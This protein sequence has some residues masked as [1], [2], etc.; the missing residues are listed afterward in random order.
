MQNERRVLVSALLK[1]EKSGYSNLILDNVL[2]E[3]DLNDVARGFVTSAFYGVIER[4]ISIDHILNRYLKR[5][6]TKAPPFTAAVLRSGAYQII[7]MDKIP[8]SA[9][10]NESVKI[11]KKS[12]ES[13]NSGL[14]NAV[15]RKLCSDDV[16]AFIEHSNDPAIRF[17]VEKWI[18]D[19]ISKEHSAKKAE[20]FF[21]NALAAPP[22]FI[23]I[24]SLKDG[25]AELLG[26]ELKERGGTLLPTSCEDLFKVDG[27]KNI[28]S[29]ECYK[30]GLFF[31]QDL[32]SRLAANIVS[33]KAGDRILDCC[34]AP[35]GKSFSVAIE[36][37]DNC[38]LIS[39]DIHPHRVALIKNGAERLGLKSV[40]LTVMDA[41]V[42]DP[43]L[44]YFDKVL[45]DV[46]CSGIGVIRRKPEIKYKT[47]SECAELI[48]LQKKILQN[49]SRYVKKGGRLIYSTCTLLRREN[50][51][52]VEAFLKENSDFV[53][54]SPLSDSEAKCINFM[55]PD[56]N[57][58]GFFIAA[59]ERK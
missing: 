2:K 28:E 13:G 50:E 25:A 47:D 27:I 10:V 58:D 36:A 41:T 15:L 46:P 9:A 20:D 16:K 31:V 37:Q 39:C 24:N 11:I 22:V 26:S 51:E 5:P 17:S 14:V 4:K 42:F 30:K 43:K 21:N 8:N 1:A 18:Y 52:V 35:G 12:K 23:R 48:P 55:P 29:F 19:L 45:C 53:L 44:G 34:A 32:S 59:M 40:K 49:S 33:A 54:V 7:F 57:G 6:I 38:E 3:S 56:T